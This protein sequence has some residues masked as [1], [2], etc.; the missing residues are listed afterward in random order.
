MTKKSFEKTQIKRIAI[1]NDT[2]E[3]LVEELRL[4]RN[5]VKL[6]LPQEDLQDYA[7]LKQIERSYKKA[8]KEYPPLSV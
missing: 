4:L 5:E 2:L 6:L 8:I 1:S 7:H 3:T